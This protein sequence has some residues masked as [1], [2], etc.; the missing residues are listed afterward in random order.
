MCWSLE[1]YLRRRTNVSQWVARGGLGFQNENA[2]HLKM[3]ARAFHGDD[4]GSVE[5][6]VQAY[7]Q[8]IEREFD[9]VLANAF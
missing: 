7:E 2:Q 3:L 1:D 4:E 9:D 6:A 8:K 5:A